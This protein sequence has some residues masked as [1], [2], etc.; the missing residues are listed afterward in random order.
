M[1][2]KS[3]LNVLPR[4]YL[5]RTHFVSVA[6]EYSERCEDESDE[7]AQDGSSTAVEL[8]SAEEE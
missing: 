1:N 3:R 4:F 6:Y 2:S 8:L 5:T 7:F